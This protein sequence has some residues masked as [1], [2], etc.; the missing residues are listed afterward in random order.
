MTVAKKPVNPSF[1]DTLGNDK[2]MIKNTEGLKALVP[3]EWT[4][5]DKIDGLKIGF[6]MKLLGIDWRTQEEFAAVMTFL[7]K[8]KVIELKNGSTDRPINNLAMIRANP[9]FVFN[10]EISFVK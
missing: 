5:M 10:T 7:T 1:L 2:W 3:T 9:A 4:T 8:I 6:A